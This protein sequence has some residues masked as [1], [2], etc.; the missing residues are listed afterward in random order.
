MVSWCPLCDDCQSVTKKPVEKS[1]TNDVK[2]VTKSWKLNPKQKGE[3]FELCSKAIKGDVSQQFTFTVVPD[4]LSKL[5]ESD[6]SAHT[7]K[8]NVWAFKTIE[9]WWVTKNTRYAADPCPEEI[10]NTDNKQILC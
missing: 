8:N 5:K 7:L 3:S 1:V 6:S 9:E 10:L 4:E 2:I